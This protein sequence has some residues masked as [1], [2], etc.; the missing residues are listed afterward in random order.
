MII[1]CVIIF[2]FVCG[3]IAYGFD[4]ASCNVFHEALYNRYKAVT[5]TLPDWG[6]KSL[7]IVG[8]FFGPLDFPCIFF[9]YKMVNKTLGYTEVYPFKNGWT[10]K[11]Y[12]G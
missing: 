12:K 2:W 8:A 5:K 3:F 4:V 11:Y 7:N 1:I 10:L 6:D 9:V